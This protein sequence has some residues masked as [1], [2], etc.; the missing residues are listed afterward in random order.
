MDY[1]QRLIEDL[2][3]HKLL[4]VKKATGLGLTTFL[5]R[6]MAWLCL[7][8]DSLKEQGR[9]EM[10]IVTGPSIDLAI[11]LISRIKDLFGKDKFD[12]KE[13]VVVLNN[14]VIKAYPSHHVSTMRGKNP[15][16]LLIDEADFFPPGQQQEVRT[17]AERY[18]AKS[19]PIIAL[20][21][22]PN[23]PGGLF[24][25]ME[26]EDQMYHKVFLPYTV[27]LGTIYWPEEIEQ[28][29]KSPSF[30]R[31][32][33]LK[34]GYGIGNIFPYQL[35]DACVEQ[36]NLALSGSSETVL[37]VDPAYGE[38]E[39]GSK[40]GM[41]GMEKRSDG[42]IYVTLAEQMTRA[43]PS[44]MLD[45]IAELAKTYY[46]HVR[47]D[48]HYKGEIRDLKER[49]VYARPVEFSKTLSE[50]TI[51]SAQAVK[52]RKVRIHPAFS[53][54]VY[55]LKAVEFNEKG[56]PDKKKLRFD[57]GDCFLMGC[58]YLKDS[59]GRHIGGGITDNNND[60]SSLSRRG[61]G[62]RE[63]NNPFGY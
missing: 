12:T 16:F 33:N 14:V 21:S 47:V 24:D 29:K 9:N 10:F 11:D 20:V 39:S 56:H 59:G 7:K 55:Q 19:D 62:Y 31:E 45:R 44:A 61:I 5:L 54:L 40:F 38:D 53:D 52:E 8:D 32:Y 15:S 41:V 22:T 2:K 25:Q 42:L 50:M 26:R 30:E 58:H 46:H 34:Y 60:S 23:L 4:W 17:I 51:V 1:E 43:S 3:K 18:I 35:V 63:G 36:Y 27:G 28:A 48:G 6:Y 57:L 13:T 49:G 37:L